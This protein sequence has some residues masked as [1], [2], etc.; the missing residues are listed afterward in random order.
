MIILNG[1]DASSHG[2][3]VIEGCF[4]EL[5]YNLLYCLTVGF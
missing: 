4:P 2:F 1:K 5:S 3:V